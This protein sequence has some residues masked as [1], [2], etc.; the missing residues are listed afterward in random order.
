MATNYN[1]VRRPIATVVQTPIIKRLRN[2]E[3]SDHDE[4]LRA[5]AAM[6]QGFLDEYRQIMKNM[7]D[8]R[9]NLYK[10]VQENDVLEVSKLRRLLR[11]DHREVTH[12]RAR[13]AEVQETDVSDKKRVQTI[14]AMTTRLSFLKGLLKRMADVCDIYKYAVRHEASIRKALTKDIP[15]PTEEFFREP[16]TDEDDYESDG[17]V[18]QVSHFSDI[19]HDGSFDPGADYA[20]VNSDTFFTPP[21]DKLATKRHAETGFV[22]HQ[23]GPAKR[24]AI[25]MHELAARQL[26]ERFQ[27]AATDNI[28]S[29]SPVTR[30][31]PS[32]RLRRSISYNNSRVQFMEDS[33]GRKEDM[34]TLRESV[35]GAEEGQVPQGAVKTPNYIG[36]TAS[37]Q[38]LT[39]AI[40]TLA[41]GT[42][43]ADIASAVTEMF[44]DLSERLLGT[45]P[46]KPVLDIRFPDGF[47][48]PKRTDFDTSKQHFWKHFIAIDLEKFNGKEDGKP[49]ASWW[50]LFDHEVHRLPEPYC[51]D[52][53]R[54]RALYKL[55]EG[56]PKATIEPFHNNITPEAYKQAVHILNSR[57][58]SNSK[59]M[60]NVKDKLRALKPKNSSCSA[61]V[62]FVSQVRGACSELQVAGVGREEASL[63]CIKAALRKM[64]TKFI[65]KYYIS[66]NLF[67]KHDKDTFYENDPEQQLMHLQ[68]WINNLKAE[69]KSS[70]EEEIQAKSNEDS[71]VT[72]FATFEDKKRFVTMNAAKKKLKPRTVKTW[73][74]P[75]HKTNNHTWM[76]CKLSLADKKKMVQ[77]EGMCGNCLRTD[78]DQEN[79]PSEIACYYC[80]TTGKWLYHHSSL[81]TSFEA[82]EAKEKGKPMDWR[83]YKEKVKERKTDS[84]SEPGDSKRQERIKKFKAKLPQLDKTQKKMAVSFLQM[85][86][87][88]CSIPSSETEEEVIVQRPEEKDTEEVQKE[89]QSGEKTKD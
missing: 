70:D 20:R 24:Q 40:E 63:M 46:R 85:L 55:M 51:S 30:S 19:T 38:K 50:K 33:A 10:A 12:L 76:Q 84:G 59:T 15:V 78:H 60:E 87:S 2:R 47:L 66:L 3:R 17:Q 69:S 1:Y 23:A 26:D 48:G 74:C 6:Y 81:C 68:A 61:Q 89:S 62:Q 27:P 4:Q 44:Q 25:D 41:K 71:T 34:Y 21:R 31:H 11:L 64:T 83:L 82:K 73:R 9:D 49:F 86:D 5:V 13:L 32:D 72:S 16:E 28:R 39:H 79:C 36:P 58:G 37:A 14:I 18:E 42:G 88:E 8:L 57:Y 77:E 54:L 53:M 75:Y 43:Q 56:E 22:N 45:S 67:S 80:M 7:A 29:T 65:D 35:P 52:T